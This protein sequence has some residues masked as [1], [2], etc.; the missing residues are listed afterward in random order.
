LKTRSLALCIVALGLAGS[1]SAQD[2]SGA[3]IE[4]V[5]TP[6]AAPETATLAA[7]SN[8]EPSQKPFYKKL[9]TAQAVMA[10]LPGAAVQ[11][12]HDWP[13]EW[14]QTGAGFEKRAASLYG[15][16]V[17]G[18]LIEDGVKAVHKED[19]RYRRLGEG[20]FFKR[21]GHA[22]ATTFVAR[23]PDGTG[24]PAFSVLANSYGSWAIATL[25]SPREYRTP[26]SIAQWG[27]TGL[28]VVVVADVFREFWP[29]L[30]RRIHSK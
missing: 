9:F 23:K 22:I 15:Q 19:T 14:G 26:G 8:Y 12:L 13:N 10:T 2:G 29:D 30:K 7:S 18:A 4:P 27:T 25:W 21:T 28:G 16:F 20:N 11:Q 6:I 1:A 17:I 5:S 3:G 24:T